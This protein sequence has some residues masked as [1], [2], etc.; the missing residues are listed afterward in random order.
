MQMMLSQIE[1]IKTIVKMLGD[2]GYEIEY[3]GFNGETIDLK[4]SKKIMSAGS[5][6]ITTLIGKQ[7]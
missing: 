6:G 5:V 7:K 1:E 4:I 2:Y 3:I